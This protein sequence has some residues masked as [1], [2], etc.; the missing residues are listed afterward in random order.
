VN[1]YPVFVFYSKVICFFFF[2]IFFSKLEKYFTE[3]L[4]KTL[5]DA[6]EEVGDD[7]AAILRHKKYGSVFS[8]FSDDAL[9][10]NRVF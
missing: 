1:C 4:R 3:D 6:L 2:W 8:C 9:D 5:A 10:Q 7:P